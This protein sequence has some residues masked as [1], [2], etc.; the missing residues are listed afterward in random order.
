MIGKEIR[1]TTAKISDLTG[2]PPCFFRPPQGVVPGAERPARSAQLTMTLWS[3][4]T[5]DW[6]THG[7]KAAQTIRA[8]ARSG[9]SE[10]NPIILMHDGGGDRRATLA[11]LPGII[12]DYRSAGYTFVTLAD[13][14]V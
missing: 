10:P 5:R 1:R 9:L 7:A 6:A 4:D 2:Q 11:A 3:V 13:G 8:R 12:A 14:R